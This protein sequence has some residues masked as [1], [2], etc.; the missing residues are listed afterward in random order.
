MKLGI[1][2]TPT[3]ESFRKAKQKGL[4]FIE[5]CVNE[6]QDVDVFYQNRENLKNGKMNMALTLPRLADGNPYALMSK[7]VSSKKS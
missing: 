1:I 3:E 5:V 4:D 6:G 7:V 2:A